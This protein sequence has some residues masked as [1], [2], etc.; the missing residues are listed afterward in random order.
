MSLKDSDLRKGC[1]LLLVF[2][3]LVGSVLPVRSA[4]ALINIYSTGFEVS[5]GYNITN[6]LAGQNGWT[7]AAR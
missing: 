3:L 4:S 2:W 7:K 1:P 5:E 6:D